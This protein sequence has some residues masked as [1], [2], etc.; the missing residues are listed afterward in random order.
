MHEGSGERR[1]TNRVLVVVMRNWLL[2]IAAGVTTAAVLLA[3]DAAGLR[4]LLLQSD[5]APVGFALL[6]GGFGITFGGLVAGTA[7]MFLPE[8][9][10]TGG[11]GKALQLIV[12][13]APVP[14]DKPVGGPY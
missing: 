1:G 10:E 7:I 5:A 4:T 9:D 11:G 8:A 3:L 6:F 13:A 2:G 12:A 14:I